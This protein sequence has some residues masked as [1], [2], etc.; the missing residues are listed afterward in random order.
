M[1]NWTSSPV[2]ADAAGADRARPAAAVDE[3]QVRAA[4]GTTMV[5]GGVAFAY[6]CFRPR[7]GA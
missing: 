1:S 2:V 7:Q 4:A 3:H 6:A 5:L